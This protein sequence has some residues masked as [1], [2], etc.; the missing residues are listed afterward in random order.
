MITNEKIKKLLSDLEADNVER[1]ISTNNA[2][3]FCQAICAFANDMS[4]RGES[5]Y[6]FIGAD[7]KTGRIKGIDI[8]DRLLQNLA[9]YRDSGQIVPLPSLQ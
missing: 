3:K 4:G 5:G 2:D 6:L 8:T 9:S 1:L 7:D